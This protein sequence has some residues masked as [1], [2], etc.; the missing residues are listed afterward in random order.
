MASHEGSLLQQHGLW[1]L[2]HRL[3]AVQLGEQRQ[4]AVLPAG[5][6]VLLAWPPPGYPVLPGVLAPTSVQKDVQQGQ[7]GERLD[8]VHV[9]ALHPTHQDP[10]PMPPDRLQAAVSAFRPAGLMHLPHVS[11]LGPTRMPL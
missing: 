4:T 6:K 1:Q 9:M 10:P 5:P 2:Q 7:Q 3:L 11:F 8:S